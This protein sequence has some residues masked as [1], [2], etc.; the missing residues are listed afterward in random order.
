MGSRFEIRAIATDDSVAKT[1]VIQAI[2][3]IKRI[4]SLIS[5]WDPHSQTSEINR[6]AGVRPVKV[7]NELFQLI[8]RSLKV[9][10]LTGGA[11]DIS[12]AS[13][14]R[15]WKFDGS[16]TA[17]PSEEEVAQSVARIGY[18]KI[19][20]NP[21]DT[22]VYLKEEGMKIGFG[23]IGKGYAATRAKEI[24]NQAGA[25]GGLVNAGGDLTCWGESPHP[26]GWKIGIANPRN[27]DQ[28]ISWISVNDLAVVTSG[29]Y[30]KFFFLEGKKYAHIIHPKTGYPVQGLQSV[31]IFCANAELADALATAVFVMGEKEG[32][33]LINQLNGIE[34]LIINDK[35]EM[36]HSDNLSLNPYSEKK[37]GNSSPH[38]LIIGKKKP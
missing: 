31:S 1:A 5:S 33:A 23:A 37:E 14:D 18:Q 4:E 8:S 27:R 9:S 3:E 13:A 32:L 12:Y 6:M 34:C 19:I 30:E 16:M 2:E 20:L 24:M 15:I 17:L 35:D 22:S 29:D 36:I 26:Q 21:A 10:Q 28:L 38:Q 7:S 11:F 25:T